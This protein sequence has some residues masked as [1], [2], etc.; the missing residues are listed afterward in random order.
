MDRFAESLGI[1]IDLYFT[2]ICWGLIFTRIFTMMI[3]NPFM[4]TRALP[5]RVRLITAVVLSLFLYPFLVPGVVESVPSDKAVILALFFKEIFFGLVIGIVTSMT[6]HALESAGRIVDDQRGG[7]NAQL[8]SPQLGQVS[9]FGLYMFWLSIAFFLSIGGHRLF[10]RAFFKTFTII[11]ILQFPNIAPGLSPF[12]DY[13]VVLSGQVLLVAVQ[14]SAPVLIAILLADIVLGIA[15]KMA[16]QINVFELGFA[17][18]GYLAPL[19]VYIAFTV[20]VLQMDKLLDGMVKS[21]TDLA[22]LLAQ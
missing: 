11:P 22:K 19:M 10:L 12:L 13:L 6:F 4:G 20:L 18:K 21:V 17:I 8:F 14:M 16:P 9:I 7:A 1:K 5:G 15:N 3:L 2:L